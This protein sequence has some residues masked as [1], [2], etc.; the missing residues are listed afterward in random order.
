MAKSKIVQYPLQHGAAGEQNTLW[1]IAVDRCFQDTYSC[2]YNS[3][4]QHWAVNVKASAFQNVAALV[5]QCRRIMGWDI[6]AD[7]KEAEA[8]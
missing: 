5:G 8:L 2:E 3:N 4:N 7:G 6:P 1:I